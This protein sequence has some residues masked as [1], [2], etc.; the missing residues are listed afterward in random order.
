M[1]YTFRC[2]IIKFNRLLRS[3]VTPSNRVEL[4]NVLAKAFQSDFSDRTEETAQIMGFNR[5]S[6]QLFSLVQSSEGSKE[7]QAVDAFLGTLESWVDDPVNALNPEYDAMKSYHQAMSN[8][9]SD[10]GSHSDYQ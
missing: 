1:L 3:G 10:G 7:Q 6:M 4:R 9:R 2:V 5:N 8:I